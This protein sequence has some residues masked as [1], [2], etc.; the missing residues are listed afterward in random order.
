MMQ[1]ILGLATPEGNITRGTSSPVKPP[2]QADHCRCRRR[3]RPGREEVRGVRFFLLFFLFLL[4]LRSRRSSACSRAA[5]A[6]CCTSL[7]ATFFA[8]SF[9]FSSSSCF[10]FNNKFCSRRNRRVVPSTPS[11]RRAAPAPPGEERPPRSAA[12]C[13]HSAA[14]RGQR[15]YPAAPPGVEASVP[16]GHRAA[17]APLPP[18]PWPSSVPVGQCGESSRPGSS[19]RSSAHVAAMSG[20]VAAAF[21]RLPLRCQLQH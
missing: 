4:L 6:C 3:A 14:A 15:D 19:R 8:C 18:R 21:E 2:L 17:R 9:A 12:R 7:S 11:S 16:A 1:S 20:A 5:A 10:F 13:G